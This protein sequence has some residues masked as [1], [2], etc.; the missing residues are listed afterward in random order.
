MINNEENSWDDKNKKP[1][2]I[3]RLKDYFKDD[4][5]NMSDNFDEFFQS[6]RSQFSK[7]EWNKFVKNFEER[8]KKGSVPG[9]PGMIIMFESD[10]ENLLEMR[11]FFKMNNKEE[12]VETINKILNTLHQKD[13]HE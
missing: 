12:Y 3:N 7:E 10:Y 4:V 2:H 6:Q 13:I 8:M 1:K 11:G 5:M 9:K